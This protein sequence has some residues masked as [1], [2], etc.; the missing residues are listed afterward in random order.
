[1][2]KLKIKKRKKSL[3]YE[4]KRLV[5]FTPDVTWVLTKSKS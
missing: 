4:E 3:F 5:G 1:M 2:A